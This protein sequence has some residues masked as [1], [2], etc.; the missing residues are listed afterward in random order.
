MKIMLL[1]SAIL[2]CAQAS[3]QWTSTELSEPKV[4]MGAVA[5]GSKVY[6]GGGFANSGYSNKVEIYDPVT[7]E[8]TMEEC[9]EARSFPAAAA[10]GGKVFFAGGI[11]FNPFQHFSRVDIYDT[12]TQEWSVAELSEPKFAV[13]AVSH[14]NKVFFAGGTNLALGATYATI[15]VYDVETEEWT[16]AALS[17]A[18]GVRAVVS[19]AKICFV[20]DSWLDIYDTG[21]G[22]WSTEILPA[23]RSFSAAAAVDGKVIIAGGMNLDN[24]P[25]DR[26]D[27]YDVATGNWTLAN[28]SMPRGFLNAAASACGKAWFAGGGSFNLN[29]NAWA[30][31][32]DRVDIYDPLGDAWTTDQLSHP[33]VNHSVVADDHHLFSAGGTDVSGSSFGTLDIFTCPATNATEED[34]HSGNDAPFFVNPATD[35]LHFTHPFAPTEPVTV[36]LVSA[37]G[38]LVFFKKSL[39]AS[40]DISHLPTG[41]YFLQ[42]KTSDLVRVGKLVKQ[43]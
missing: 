17:Q 25:T 7:G 33:V 40:F 23:A 5:Y 34:F 19:G 31:A 32:S 9:S 2:V 21:T 10:N 3:G 13:A 4:Q 41:I 1:F 30:S 26:V 24:T 38:Q 35:F 11:T 6:F 28:L 43:Q 39:A 29:T 12:L 27:I 16:T 14:G 20:G 42:V 18:G 37:I 36:M 8:W 22:I 15:D